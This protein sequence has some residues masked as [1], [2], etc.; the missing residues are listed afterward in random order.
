MKIAIFVTRAYYKKEHLY[1]VSGHVQIPLKAVCLI[2]DTM[3]TVD[4]ITTKPQ[5]CEYLMINVPANVKIRT[6]INATKEWPQKGIF[7]QKGILQFFQLVGI[8]NKEQYDVVHFFGGPKTGLLAA[9]IKIVNSKTRIFFSPISQPSFDQFSIT[10]CLLTRLH[11][12]LDCIVSTSEYVKQKWSQL[13]GKEKCLVTKPST[14]KNLSKNVFKAEND[15]VLFWRN[16]NYDNGVDIM[17]SVVK[18]IASEYK[19]IRFVFAIRPGDE[20]QD[21]LLQLPRDYNNVYVHVYPYE[22]GV[23][24]ESLLKETLFVVAPYRKLSINPQISILETLL[25]GVPV[26]ASNVE[27]N[28]EV[29]QDGLTGLIVKNNNPDAF[30]TAIK[31]LLNDREYLS[32]LANNTV[33]ET[34]I[35]YNWV[36]FKEQL[37]NAYEQKSM[38][39][40]CQ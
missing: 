34:S 14:L 30:V 27:S 17:I 9:F 26:V 4:F 6:V 29:I 32:M 3:S 8:I 15:I 33:S 10:G 23:T 11:K 21:A 38:Q 31:I 39:R 18:M 13:I 22:N 7:K 36:S 40:F 25:A 28:N 5:N 12:R 20:F 24:L 1:G 16:A 19:M 2:A 37:L 35:K